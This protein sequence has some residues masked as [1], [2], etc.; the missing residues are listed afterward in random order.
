MHFLAILYTLH[1]V[2]GHYLTTVLYTGG[3]SEVCEYL[4]VLMTDME[5]YCMQVTTINT[6]R[7]GANGA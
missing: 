4:P 6:I 1:K 5:R 3:K 7:V 2:E